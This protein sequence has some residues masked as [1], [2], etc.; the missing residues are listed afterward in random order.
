MFSLSSV[1]DAQE[2]DQIKEGIDLIQNKEYEKAK[3]IFKKI[4]KGQPKNILANFN[5]GKIYYKVGDFE[6]AVNFFNKA[7]NLNNKNANYYIWLGKA[8]EGKLEDAGLFSFA[9]IT[10]K[11]KSNFEKAIEI[12]PDNIEA[13]YELAKLLN[14]ASPLVGGSDSKA[15]E[16]LK[17]IQKR[18]P[19][20]GYELSAYF[21]WYEDE[22][23]A[24]I[25]DY[26]KYVK[27][28]TNN[29]EVYY[30]LGICFLQLKDYNNAFKNFK[31]LI[32]INPLNDK[33]HWH[34][35]RLYLKRGGKEQARIEYERA[36]QINPEKE[37][38]KKALNDL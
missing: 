18:D 37:L 13:R 31:T 11:M 38:Y 2:T 14:N 8:Y 26:Q 21:H 10:S 1:L 29:T 6:N 20:K 12:D 4:M 27:K 19:L 22:W 35:G 17:E 36:I 30:M 9:S 24:A 25:K 33:A 3:I 16:Q 34:L 23:E 7:I 28:D 15:R 32:K 5:L